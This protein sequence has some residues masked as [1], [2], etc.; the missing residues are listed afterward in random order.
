MANAATSERK[1]IRLDLKNVTSLEDW[2]LLL[3]QTAS[4]YQQ[5]YVRRYM[6]PTIPQYKALCKTLSELQASGW[7]CSGRDGKK[8]PNH[9]GLM[10]MVN[11]CQKHEWKICTAKESKPHPSDKFLP[12]C[13]YCFVPYA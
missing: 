8:G 12:L 6:R 5:D 1:H 11:N 9:H 13:F 10:T 4:K 3:Q 2:I 7:I